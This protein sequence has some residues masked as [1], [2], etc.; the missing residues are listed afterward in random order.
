MAW[1]FIVFAAL[2]VIGTLNRETTLGLLWLSFAVAYPHRWRWLL[3]YAG[4]GG[5]V[6]LGIRLGITAVPSH[7]TIPYVWYLNTQTWNAQ[8]V[9]LYWGLLICPAL[10]LYWGAKKRLLVRSSIVLIP[11]LALYF[12]FGVWQEVRLLMPVYIMGMAVYGASR[13]GYSAVSPMGENPTG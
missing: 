1:R 11:Y 7:Y 3:L 13:R 10:F 4:L 6:L 8:A 12:L 2:V 9:P 5:G